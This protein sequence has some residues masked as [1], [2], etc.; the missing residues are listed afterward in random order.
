MET[1]I[2]C[3]GTVLAKLH[4][5]NSISWKYF[6]TILIALIVP[7]GGLAL[8]GAWLLRREGGYLRLLFLAV[9]LTSSRSKASSMVTSSGEESLGRVAFTR[10]WLT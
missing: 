9:F 5:M 8:L 1:L 7:G 4:L 6:A 2:N 3:P 10:P